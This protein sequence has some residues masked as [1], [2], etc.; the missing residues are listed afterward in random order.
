MVS[1]IPAVVRQHG[2]WLQRVSVAA[3]SIACG[4]AQACLI[5]RKNRDSRRAI[6]CRASSAAGAVAAHRWAS[7]A[8]HRPAESVR[9]A[10]VRDGVCVSAVGAADAAPDSGIARCVAVEIRPELF[11]QSRIA[12]PGAIRE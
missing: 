7:S 9:V 6:A 5:G 3:Q 2:T 8:R 1:D 4:E 10:A 12:K 11:K